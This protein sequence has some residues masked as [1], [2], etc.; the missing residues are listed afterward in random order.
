MKP[1]LPTLHEYQTLASTMKDSNKSELIYKPT[2]KTK[3]IVLLSYRSKKQIQFVV[4]AKLFLT[5]RQGST[6]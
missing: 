3:F 2:E 6:R 1:N 4:E 5:S